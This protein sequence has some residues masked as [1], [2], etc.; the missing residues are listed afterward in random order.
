MNTLATYLPNTNANAYG[1]LV[2]PFATLNSQRSKM[3]VWAFAAA[4]RLSD[5]D[6]PIVLKLL[7]ELAIGIRALGVL[8]KN[9]RCA[10]GKTMAAKRAPRPV[11]RG[12][13][14]ISKAAKRSSAVKLRQP[15][16]RALGRRLPAKSPR[17]T[18]AWCRSK[19]PAAVRAMPVGGQ[20]ARA[21][22]PIA[23]CIQ[24][25]LKARIQS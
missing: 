19:R 13:A 2:S 25:Q 16:V 14:R 17:H 3:R 10:T 18:E 15:G 21:L 20:T 7:V 11:A 9:A 23:A 5:Q 22:H 1:L 12:S 24:V 6:K 8:I 4:V